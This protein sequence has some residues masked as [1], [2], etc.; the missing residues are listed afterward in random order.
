MKKLQFLLVVAMLLCLNAQAQ[1]YQLPNAGFESW[2]GTTLTGNNA[3]EPTH[4][5][6]FSS[7]DGSYASMASSNHHAHRYGGRPGTTGSSFLTIWTKSIIGIKANGNMTTGRIH[8]GSMSASSSNNYNY[9][10]RS[11]SDHSCP[12]TGTPDSMYVWVSYYAASASSVGAITSYIHGDSDFVDPNDWNDTTKY[13]GYAKARFNRTTTSA[14]TYGWEQIKVPFIYDGTTPAM[15]NLVSITTNQTPGSGSANDSLSVDDIEFIY[16]AWLNDI[17]V[18]NISIDSF[19][20]ATFSYTLDGFID[21]LFQGVDITWTPEASDATVTVDSVDFVDE[22]SQ[23]RHYTLHVVAEDQIT[24]KDYHI[25]CLVTKTER[26]VPQ[27][28]LVVHSADSIMGSVEGSGIFEEG[29]EVTIQAIPAQGYYFMN[30]N[31]GDTCN[32]RI[33][34]L[35]S[36]TSFTAFFDAMESIDMAYMPQLRIYPNP[37]RDKV[38]IQ[39]TS[40]EPLYLMDMQ[41]RILKTVPQPGNSTELNLSSYPSGTYILRQG[42]QRTKVIKL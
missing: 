37:T 42:T 18:N 14:T 10:Q 26:P 36:D 2:D 3:S 1:T 39:T 7:S 28:R 27:Y 12:F 17:A 29:T 34:T 13:C 24:T 35:T 11:N 33:I 4:W 5:N 19:S 23:G 21:T 8:A 25:Y 41:G 9:T 16:S 31:D 38:T 20:K 15:Y 22:E 6:T 30:W 32:P 40:S